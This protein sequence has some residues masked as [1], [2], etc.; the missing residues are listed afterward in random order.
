MSIKTIINE[1][2]PLILL[3]SLFY[4]TDVAL[5]FNLFYCFSLSIKNPFIPMKDRVQRLICSHARSVYY[6]IESIQN[7][8]AFQAKR[9]SHESIFL[10]KEKQGDKK[11]TIYGNQMGYYTKRIPGVY[12]VKTKSSSPFSC[13]NFTAILS[14]IF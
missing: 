10:E 6:Y 8:N 3:L 9:W 2:L 14:F 13:K 12:Y 11:C 4:D 1:I 7:K 5:L